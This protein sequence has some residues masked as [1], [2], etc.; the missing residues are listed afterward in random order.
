MPRPGEASEHRKNQI[1]VPSRLPVV[2]PTA[3]GRDDARYAIGR[4]VTH[5]RVGA[6]HHDAKNC[7]SNQEHQKEHLR[8]A[9]GSVQ[10]R[11]QQID[12]EPRHQLL[13]C[14]LAGCCKQAKRA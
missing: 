13:K 11:G 9:N 8:G 10:A 14:W 7:R 1:K 6:E 12:Q 3:S 4:E 5:Q 2:V